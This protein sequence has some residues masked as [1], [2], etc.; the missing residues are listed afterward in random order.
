MFDAG[1]SPVN[2]YLGAQVALTETGHVV[3]HCPVQEH[4][5]QETGVVQGGILSAVAD[6][7]A[8]LCA[9]TVLKTGEMTAGIE[10]KVNF[11]APARFPGLLVAEGKVRK[12]G[13]KIAVVD[14]E[15]THD[16]QLVLTGI[17]T[18]LIWTPDKK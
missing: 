5:I 12:R 16:N 11:L 14:A 7:A 4:F 9:L 15:I 18:F 6:Q 1:N 2:R 17:F 10:F 3:V 8:G 13:G